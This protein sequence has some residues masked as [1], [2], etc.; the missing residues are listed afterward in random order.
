MVADFRGGRVVVA[1]AL[2]L[3]GITSQAETISGQVIGV[4]DGD[5]ITVLDSSKQQHKIRLAGIDAPEKQ[6]PFGERSKQNLVELTF[7]KDVSVNWRKKHRDRLIGKVTVN[8]ADV[9]LEQ[10][11]A[12][13]AWW[14]EK[15]RK[16]Q[17]PDD[18]RLYAKGEQQARSE[19]VGLWRDPA[20][21][22]PWQWRTAQRV[23]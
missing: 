12:G 19:R 11:K 4:T 9:S 21:V 23:R 20:P 16:E 22:A 17:S 3:L 13:M 6:Q 2:V 14:Y 10:L 1:L 18:Q 8:G 15:Y 5:T 7:G